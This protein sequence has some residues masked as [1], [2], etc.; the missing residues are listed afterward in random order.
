MGFEKHGGELFFEGFRRVQLPEGA[1]IVA[2]EHFRSRAF[3]NGSGGD[4]RSAVAF[5]LSA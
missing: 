4:Q 2:D 5:A 1:E 3:E